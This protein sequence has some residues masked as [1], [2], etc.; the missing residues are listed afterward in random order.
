MQDD[1]Q[2]IDAHLSG[3]ANGDCV[4]QEQR[5]RVCAIQ[6]YVSLS[7]RWAHLACS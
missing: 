6:L 7:A 4:A 2:Q 3:G 1:L 5:V